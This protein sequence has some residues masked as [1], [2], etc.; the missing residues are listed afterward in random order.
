MKC[1]KCGNKLTGKENFCRICGTPI[2]HNEEKES[3][4][5]ENKCNIVSNDSN[6][7]VGKQIELTGNIDVTKIQLINNSNDNIED[8]SG[9]EIKITKESAD[10]EFKAMLEITSIENQP[11]R[12]IDT[13]NS[14]VT[15]EIDSNTI[16]EEISSV[17][18][19]KTDDSE[20]KIDVMP[21]E[22]SALEIQSTSEIEELLLDNSEKEK[23][24]ISDSDDK[25]PNEDKQD[26]MNE[27]T[28]FIPDEL[29]V[30]KNDKKEVETETNKALELDEITTPLIPLDDQKME[31]V[32]DSVE[33]E[34]EKQVKE[35]Q[36]KEVI[37]EEQNDDVDSS[38]NNDISVESS[39][40]KE[41]STTLPLVKKDC[42][43]NLNTTVDNEKEILQPIVQPSKNSKKLLVILSLFLFV[44]ILCLSYLGYQL[45][46][47]NDDFNNLQNDNKKLV[48]E[49]E[50]IEKQNS[51]NVQSNETD[52]V[53]KINGYDITLDKQ[54]EYS[55]EGDSL[56]VKNKSNNIIVN[57][58]LNI[59]YDTIKEKDGRE[60]YKEFL[61]ENDYDIQSY[62]TKYSED[63][64]YVV[65]EVKNK[66]DKKILIAYTSLSN[67]NTICFMIS[68]SDNQIDYDS[69]LMTN[70]IV[71]SLAFNSS[72]NDTHS[73]LFIKEENE[74]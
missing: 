49:I 69:L 42:M 74:S 70:E 28:M 25:V 62:G 35:E 3:V 12:N 72:I 64:E 26:E 44:C 61:I 63:R 37:T 43:E 5:N 60:S 59:D 38:S 1:T 29:I 56:L 24:D 65:Y 31:I 51:Q 68:N 36:E 10:K 11:K 30:T 66:D 45:F 27:S 13:T 15:N 16:E 54:N 32:V 14:L 50:T 40:E 23:N 2:I 20:M 19:S 47:L 17:V 41:L 9:D 71:D 21:G 46:V 55:I 8:V 52:S 22:A 18:D 39:E 58:G 73:N 34:C 57:F 7:V 53:L 6:K 33:P 4:L 67:K 48:N